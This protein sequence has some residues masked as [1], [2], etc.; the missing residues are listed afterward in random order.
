[1]IIPFFLLTACSEDDPAPSLQAQADEVASTAQSGEWI[2]TYYFD[3]V[4][5]TSDYAGYTFTFENNGVLIAV[6]DNSPVNGTWS[7]TVDDDSS[8]DNPD[9]SDI[10]FN[11][12]FSS[13]A[14][15]AELTDDWDVKSR[16]S[17]RIELI[18]V[19]GGDGTTEYLTFERK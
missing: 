2:I 1:M 19:S 18:D 4:D 16:S 8:D 13:P 6:K 3:E 17:S 15:L 9:E 7:V 11:I 12:Q 14:V 5:E 10:D